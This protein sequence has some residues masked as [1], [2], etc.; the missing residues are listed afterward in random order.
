MRFGMIGTG[1]VGR[2]F[3][4]RLLAAGRPL[5]VLDRCN[6]ASATLFERGA[7]PASSPRALAAQCDIVLTCLPGPKELDEVCSGPDGF[8]ADARAGLVHVETST[9]GVDATRELAAHAAASGV[10][11]VDAPMSAGPRQGEHLEL[12]LFVGAR[13]LAFVKLKAEL[14]ILAEHVVLCGPPGNGQTV[15]LINNYVTLSML[16]PL[17]EAL[18]LGVKAGVPLDV[19]RLALPWGTG[20]SRLLGEAFP[21]SVFAGD[22]RPGYRTD[23]AAKDMRLAAALSGEHDA[24]LSGIEGLLEACAAL[25]ERGLGDVSVHSIVRL[26]EERAGVELR[27]GS[28]RIAA[29]DAAPDKPGR[30]D[31]GAR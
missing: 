6:E 17:G 1:V 12:T 11:Y 13:T 26:A 16:E 18:C 29:S 3:G 19:L 28:R 2:E 14:E 15:K 4:R 24:P 27:V 9:I 30:G 25:E 31:D 8:Y 23:L 22:W 7:S 10:E 20:A 21:Y 5:T